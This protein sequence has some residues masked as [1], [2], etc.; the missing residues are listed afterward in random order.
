MDY[1]FTLRFL[2][3][4][5]LSAV[6]FVLLDYIWLARLAS[7]WYR[8][9]LGYLAN[10]DADGK[11]TFNLSF[12]LLAQIAISLLLS[13]L[14]GLTLQLDQRLTTLLLVGGLGGCL[15]YAVFD[16]TNLSFVKN[17]PV[18]IS[19]IDIAWGTIQGAAA[20]A[21]AYLLYK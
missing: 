13:I 20:G 10:L 1:F 19:L 11:I 8:Q 6:V 16:F 14:L 15:I 18:W 17:W 2:K 9:A 21:L 4:A 5:G 7:P 12:G 3:I